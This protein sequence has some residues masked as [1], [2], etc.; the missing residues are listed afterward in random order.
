VYDNL[1]VLLIFGAVYPLMLLISLSSL[2]R[3]IN[4]VDFSKYFVD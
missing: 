4:S 2:K 1:S 3:S